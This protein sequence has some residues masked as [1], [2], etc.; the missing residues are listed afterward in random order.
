MKGLR[1][2]AR[3]QNNDQ[4]E[5]ARHQYE[6]Y[7]KNGAHLFLYRNGLSQLQKYRAAA[8]SRDQIVLIRLQ[9]KGLTA[10]PS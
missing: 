8:S 9:Y 3:S 7:N 10:D 1:A 2:A 4:N 5:L 6:V